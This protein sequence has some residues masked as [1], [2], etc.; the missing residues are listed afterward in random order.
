MVS[1]FLLLIQAKNLLII[2]K[3][4]SGKEFYPSESETIWKTFWMEFA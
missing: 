1:Y 3:D 2:P 4:T